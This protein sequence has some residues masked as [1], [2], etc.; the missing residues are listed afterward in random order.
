MKKTCLFLSMVFSLLWMTSCGGNGKSGKDS[1]NTNADTT[2]TES[3]ASE[4]LWAENDSTLYGRADG[5]GQSALTF[6]ANDGKEYDLS[7]TDYN[8]KNEAARIYGDRED[9]A[10]YALTLSNDKEA[11]KVMINLSQL[12]KFSNRYDIHNC[13]LALINEGKKDVV[14]II[15][16]TDSLFEARGESGT[17]YQSG[18]QID[19]IAG[20]K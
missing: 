4:I 20:N 15:T 12:D 19:N 7:L 2:V 9:T 16:L 8:E 18:R 5:F 14:E 13:H 11:V 3:A 6:I 10:R 1:D 17:F